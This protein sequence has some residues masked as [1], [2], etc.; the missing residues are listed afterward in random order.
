[1]SDEIE[2]IHS[3][4]LDAKKAREEVRR[5]HREELKASWE[6]VKKSFREMPPENKEKLVQ[7]LTP[8]RI[9][10]VG[11]TVVCYRAFFPKLILASYSTDRKISEILTA[12][13]DADLKKM[14]SALGIEIVSVQRKG[15]RGDEDNELG[16]FE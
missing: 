7:S 2:R 9:L 11:S 1:M 8:S 5:K 13:P 10:I 4:E 14:E 15:E 6:A 12:N 16:R 3:E